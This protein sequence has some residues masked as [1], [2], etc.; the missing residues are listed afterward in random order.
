MIRVLIADDHALVRTGF[1]LLL[2]EPDDIEVV[3][4]AESGEQA[5][6]LYVEVKPD[7]IMIDLAMPGI[8][9]IEAIKKIIARDSTARILTLSAHEDIS[10][11]KR[12]MQAGALGYL[13]KRQAPEVL[14]DAIRRIAKGGRVI[15]PELAQQMAMAGVSGS[16]SPLESLSE[17]EFEV[18]EKLAL[19]KSVS[20]IAETLNL[21]P[22][23][24]GTHLYKV[25]QKLGLNN[26]AEITLLAVRYGVIE[27]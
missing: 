26:Q 1:R 4:E 6:Q 18:F 13:S 16:G 5:Y 12:V 19:G 27:P 9:G 23:T 2:D 14:I 22:S 17:R 15:D 25:K 10:H 7:V 3:A 20:Q 8:G 21:S 11:P 24:V